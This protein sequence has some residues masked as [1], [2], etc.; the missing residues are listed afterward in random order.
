MIAAV[1]PAMFKTAA[2]ECDGVKLH[3]FCTRSY[4]TD[5]IMP[6]LAAGWPRPGE[7]ARNSRSRA[8]AFSAPGRTTPRSGGPI[9]SS[10]RSPSALAASSTH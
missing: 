9:R 1:G 8:A 3:G 2:E 6:R 5:A 4:L 7:R 10:R